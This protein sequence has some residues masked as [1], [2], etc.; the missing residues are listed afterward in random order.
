M[1]RP[2]P[3]IIGAI[4]AGLV[5]LYKHWGPFH[6]GIDQL[7]QIIQD[8]WDWIL[9][10]WHLIVPL[11]AGPLG[12]VITLIIKHWD[13]VKA[14]LLWVYHKVILP[15]FNGIKWFITNVVVPA[16]IW[17]KDKAI[18]VFDKIKA[19]ISWAWETSSSRSSAWSS[20]TSSTS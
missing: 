3:I 20:G 1:T 16:F 19:A 18:W 9:E 11:I 15:I 5:L 8:V 4:I 6:R 13:K 14:A 12:L 17:L 7:W 10:H 2:D